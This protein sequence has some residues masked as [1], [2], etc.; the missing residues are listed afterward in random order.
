MIHDP[1][2]GTLYQNSNQNPFQNHRKK[3]FNQRIKNNFYPKIHPQKLPQK[4]ILLNYLSQPS[5]QKSST[6][7]TRE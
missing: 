7:K 2:N 6:E 4:I 5:S 1:H 3:V